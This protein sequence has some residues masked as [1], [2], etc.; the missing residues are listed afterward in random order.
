MEI[1]ISICVFFVAVA[2]M[3][4]GILFGRHG[5]QG[6]CGGLNRI[7][8]LENACGGCDKPCKNRQSGGTKTHE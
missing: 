5:V 4:I 7:P 8:G 1:L 6:S 3:N 2:A